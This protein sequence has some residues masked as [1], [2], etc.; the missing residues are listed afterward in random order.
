MAALDGAVAVLADRQMAVQH[1]GGMRKVEVDF[2][3]GAVGMTIA[4]R[5]SADVQKLA[6]D[7]VA[8]KDDLRLA[9]MQ[10]LAE[11]NDAPGPRC[12]S[13]RPRCAL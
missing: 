2:A 1:K 8:L 7:L 5:L 13:G 12:G 4:E 6:L 10:K 9:V 11:C 3:T